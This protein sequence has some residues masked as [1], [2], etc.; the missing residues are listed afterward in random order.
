MKIKFKILDIPKLAIPRYILLFILLIPT[1]TK[2]YIFVLGLIIL[3]IL[4]L[5]ISYICITYFLKIEVIFLENELHIIKRSRFRKDVVFKL[6]YSDIKVIKI[7]DNIFGTKNIS[8]N[9]VLR[10]IN[11][12]FLPV[13]FYIFFL[14]FSLS[15]NLNRGLMLLPNVINCGEILE[16]LSEKTNLDIKSNC[17]IQVSYK[18]SINNYVDSLSGVLLFFIVIFILLLGYNLLWLIVIVIFSNLPILKNREY[19]I[20]I[21]GYILKVA[22]KNDITFFIDNFEINENKIYI[23]IYR[24]GLIKTSTTLKFIMV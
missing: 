13:F 10:G 8:L 11:V 21:N 24:Y 16:K 18:L 19:F 3:F 23:K 2:T 1:I 22:S 9:Y 4:N 20:D 5:I 17:K 7:T 12:G 15:T 6:R 14:G